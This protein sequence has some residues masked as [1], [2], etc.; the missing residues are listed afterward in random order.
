[1]VRVA[2]LCRT[3]TESR[4]F[5]LSSDLGEPTWDPMHRSSESHDPVVVQLPKRRFLTSLTQGLLMSTL[6][7]L[8]GANVLVS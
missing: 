1:M 7:D 5:M 3:L 8:P 2:D 6:I 4:V